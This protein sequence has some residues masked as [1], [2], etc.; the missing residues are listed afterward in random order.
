MTPSLCFDR[1]ST[2]KAAELYSQTSS[3]STLLHG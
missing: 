3:F 2:N 1:L